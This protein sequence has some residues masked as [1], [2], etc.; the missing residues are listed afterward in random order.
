MNSWTLSGAVAR[1]VS[2]L[3]MTP[4]NKNYLV[5]KLENQGWSSY[6]SISAGFSIELFSKGMCHALA[7][8]GRQL[9]TSQIGC[10]ESGP[11]TSVAVAFT[12][13]PFLGF[14]FTCCL[15]DNVSSEL[16]YFLSRISCLLIHN[17]YISDLLFNIFQSFT[18]L[19]RVVNYFIEFP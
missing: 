4:E 15:F 6:S 13:I 7:R 1:F 19:S 16:T 18:G 12:D 2:E 3:Q 14:H 5:K 17:N 11:F 9:P 8:S 10:Q